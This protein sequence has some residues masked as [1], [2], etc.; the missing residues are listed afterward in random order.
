[1]HIEC[2]RR[3]SPAPIPQTVVHA[4]T[5]GRTRHRDADDDS[6]DVQRSPPHNFSRPTGTAPSGT[7]ATGMVAVKWVEQPLHNS[8]LRRSHSSTTPDSLCAFVHAAQEE[9]RDQIFEADAVDAT[10]GRPE[11]WLRRQP[12]VA[13]RRAR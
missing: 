12:K 3:N 7:L 8:A 4:R 9:S 10:I 5:V 6:D 13:R 11:R 2:T 1:M